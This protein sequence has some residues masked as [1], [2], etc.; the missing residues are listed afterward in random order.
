MRTEIKTNAGMMTRVWLWLKGFPKRHK[1]ITTL[2]VLY[3]LWKLVMTPI[4]NPFAH[5]VYTIRGRFPFDQGFELMFRQNAYGNAK[6]YRRQCGGIQTDDAI[7]RDG[8]R[9]LKPTR[10]DGQRYE[11]KIYR[12][13][14][15]A[16]F[17]DWKEETWHVEYKANVGINPEKMPAD[18]YA[19][20]E[21][22]A[23]NGSS[24]SMERHKGQ[25]FCTG[26]LNDKD[27]KHLVINEGLPLKPNERLLNFWLYSDLDAMLLKEKAQ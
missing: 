19:N 16:A 7:C 21:N 22:S 24:E 20:E 12:D 11:I 14:Y 27:Y 17:A 4:V 15:F 10:L 1:V 25:L 23:C 18:A 2:A 6:W 8:H 3:V 9:V 5:D 13:R 26:H